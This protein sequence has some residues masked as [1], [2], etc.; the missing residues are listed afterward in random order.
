MRVFLD[1]MPQSTEE[2]GLPEKASGVR[3][4]DPGS[5]YTALHIWVC[6]HLLL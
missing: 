2:E 6:G 3:A 1:L 5:P 4:A